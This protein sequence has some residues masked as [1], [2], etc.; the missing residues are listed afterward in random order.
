M[1]VLI[2]PDSFFLLF[3]LHIKLEPHNAKQISE[4]FKRYNFKMKFVLFFIVALFAYNNSII[5]VNGQISKSLLIISCFFNIIFWT[6][7]VNQC[8]GQTCPQNATYCLKLVNTT[9]N[10][11]FFTFQVE[12]LN[13]NCEWFLPITIRKN[14]YF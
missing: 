1:I 8:Y 13:S 5:D 3:N 14:A 9:R 7:L 2:T 6:G 10:G 12:C 11:Q 4:C